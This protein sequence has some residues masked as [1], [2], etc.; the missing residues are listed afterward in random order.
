VL[1]ILITRGLDQWFNVCLSGLLLLW[2]SVVAV[3]LESC[4]ELSSLEDG[5][6]NNKRNEWQYSMILPLFPMFGFA[7]CCI[8]VEDED[9]L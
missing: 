4:H 5:I 9:I 6:K 2:C 1:C 3:R 7:E 8:N